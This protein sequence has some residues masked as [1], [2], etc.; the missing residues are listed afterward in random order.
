MRV[1]AAVL[2]IAASPALFAQSS[3]AVP[4]CEVRP[5]VRQVLDAKLSEKALRNLK[6]SEQNALRTQ[7]LEEL[8]AQYPRE[9]EPPRRLIQALRN[10]ET[11]QQYAAVMAEYRKRAEQHP[12]DPLVLFLAGQV[13][14]GRDT[15]Q[16]IRFLEQAR[17]EAPN[18]AWPALQLAD[19]YTMS[20]RVDKKKADELLAAFFAI[21]P[22]SADH[23][24]QRLLSR[25][26]SVELRARVA[27]ALR[28]RL[29][30]ETDPNR[31]EAYE[32]LRGLE[33]RMHPPQEHDSLRKQV[34][35]DL[36]RLETLNP[37]PDAEWLVF[38]KNGYKQSG[39]SAETVTAMEERVLQAFP[40]SVEAYEIV[41]DRWDKAHKE[42]EDQK[43]AAAW[44][45][46]DAAYREAV[47]GWIGRFTESRYV[48]HQLLFNV[49]FDDTG[50]TEKEGLSVLDDYL[51]EISEYQR[52]PYYG[53]TAAASFLVE[54]KWQPERALDLLRK[55]E[56]LTED[57]H[58]RRNGDNLSA[59]EEKMWA[60][61]DLYQQEHL[62]GLVLRAAKMARRSEEADRLKTAI[63]GP[64]PKDIKF[65]SAYWVNRARLAALEGRKID[66]LTYYQKG[67]NTRQPPQARRG[68]LKDDVADEAR[69]LWKETGG[70]EVA[71]E[72]WSQPSAGKVQELAEGRWEKPVKAMPAFELGDLSGKTWRIKNLE[73][74]SV[75]INVWAT[76]CGPCQ[77]ELPKLEK[78]Y[79]QIKDR[80]D[81][82]IL[83]FNIDEDLGL[84]APFVKD[85]GFTFP[86]LPA[87][88]LVHELDLLGIPQNWLVDPKG[89]W[90]WSQI[91]YDASDGAWTETMVGKLES[92]KAK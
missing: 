74:K 7:V 42:P 63:E 8:I 78:L 24:A 44:A 85:K 55:A 68:K 89:D 60:E 28:A 48:Q 34:A 20:K 91:G 81:F 41:S 50:V 71:W 61:N 66:A 15:P 59:E 58:A 4:G 45:R 73:G 13:L 32:T 21:C 2:L 88:S 22:S 90:R 75:L 84:V 46:Y 82:Q 77:A 56:E 26:G 29:A 11:A 40:H 65:E 83:T 25:V 53:F 17:V 31:L 80:S 39:A 87:Y 18:F 86:V 12:H 16:S 54:H 27:V 92:M 49:I 19:T 37:K 3:A 64:P 38:L 6:F 67:L 23:G 35:A 36:Q 62:A 52:P 76:W 33:F 51:T 5:E 14:S 30:Q 79:E 10:S 47:K 9:L 57:W 43:D 1:P 72:V 70:T 69:A